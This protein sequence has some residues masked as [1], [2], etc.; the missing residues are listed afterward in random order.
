[1][2]RNGAYALL[3]AVLCFV[4]MDGASSTLSASDQAK[5]RAQQMKPEDVHRIKSMFKK[6]NEVA[7]DGLY[8]MNVLKHLRQTFTNRLKN[9]GQTMD[10][11][12]QPEG[13]SSK[14]T[15]HLDANPNDPTKVNNKKQYLIHTDY[16][17]TEHKLIEE[18]PQMLKSQAA[19]LKSPINSDEKKIGAMEDSILKF[20]HI[21]DDKAANQTHSEA[22]QTS[23][24]PG[25][26][27]PTTPAFP[28]SM[29]SN[30]LMSGLLKPP[31][32]PHLPSL[33]P[34]PAFSAPA[35]PRPK[36]SVIGNS[37]G[38]MALTN[39]NVVVVNVLSGNY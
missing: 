4:L 2:I 1:M 38:P 29:N 33:P 27:L 16:N 37:G 36:T 10:S 19:L 39:D 8:E 25:F 32:F 13:D 30:P 22:R 24:F 18:A 7:T 11:R 23:L 28:M 34:F 17:P 20:L 21:V 3:A 5:Q 9:S 26:Q 31:T 6:S 15:V 14:I 35:A 12:G